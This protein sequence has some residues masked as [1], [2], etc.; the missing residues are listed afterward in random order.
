[1]RAF[2]I[3]KQSKISF[4]SLTCRLKWN[5]PAF[6]PFTPPGWAEMARPWRRLLSVDQGGFLLYLSLAMPSLQPPA[7]HIPQLNA[8]R[9][10][11]L[12]R[13]SS[14]ASVRQLRK[15]SSRTSPAPDAGARPSCAGGETGLI[16]FLQRCCSG[17]GGASGKE[18][19]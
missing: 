15:G 19:W 7:R 3:G 18:E 2:C 6:C 12:Q 13:I 14:C 1:M 9:P 5:S 11:T 16:R 10:T 4:P 17:R 8:R